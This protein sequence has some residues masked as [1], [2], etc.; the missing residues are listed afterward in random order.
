M[1]WRVRGSFPV[2]ALPWGVR[3][4]APLLRVTG[5]CGSSS[6][7]SALFQRLS[8]AVRGDMQL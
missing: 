1:G 3:E 5:S 4:E 2:P 6:S 8:P 7:L